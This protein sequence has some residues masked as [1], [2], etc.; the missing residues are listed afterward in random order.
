MKKDQSVEKIY[1]ISHPVLFLYL[2][3]YIERRKIKCLVQKQK[4][5][6]KK[7]TTVLWISRTV[8]NLFKVG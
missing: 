7:L 4:K 5:A 2:K 1:K 6:L 3:K 8:K